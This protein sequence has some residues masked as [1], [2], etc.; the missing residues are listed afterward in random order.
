MSAGHSGIVAL[1]LL[2]RRLADVD[3]IDLLNLLAD[4]FNFIRIEALTGFE[5]ADLA[6]RRSPLGIGLPVD[7]Q[8]LSIARIGIEHLQLSFFLKELL[9]L[10]RAMEIDPRLA[11]LLQLGQ[12][13]HT[14][15]D[16]DAGDLRAMYA[17]LEQEHALLTGRQTGRVE[18]AVDHL[19]IC[20]IKGRLHFELILPLTDHRL[21]GARAGEQAKGSEQH[22]LARAR[23]PR[24]S[25]EAGSKLQGDLIE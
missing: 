17:T 4:E 6:Q 18:Q 23:F 16:L 12:G 3:G 11:E 1:Q 9:R 5:F 2:N 10:T 13:R 8:N 15:V 20:K 21:I 22:T 25:S 14:A 24:H 19:G 7:R